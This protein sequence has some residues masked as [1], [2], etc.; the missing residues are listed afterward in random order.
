VKHKQEQ[1]NN[2]AHTINK[3]L[4]SDIRSIYIKTNALHANPFLKM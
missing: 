1:L 2:T 3:H 4:V